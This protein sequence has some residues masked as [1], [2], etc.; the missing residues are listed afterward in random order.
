V[1]APPA[2]PIVAA[3]PAPRRAWRA[4]LAALLWALPLTAVGVLWGR[5]YFTL[6]EWTMVDRGNVLRGAVSYRGALYAIRAEHNSPPRSLAWDTYDV[7]RGATLF[8]LY[9][10]RT[11]EQVRLGFLIARW[12]PTAPAPPPGAMPP[13]A[14]SVAPWLFTP[15]FVAYGVPF[16]P[17]AA[18]LS[19]PAGRAAWRLLLR[20]R[21]ARRGLCP[22]CGYDVRASETLCPE[23]AQPVPRRRH[24]PAAT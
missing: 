2:N 9:D 18:A 16:W 20:A 3:I 22:G 23:C 12:P 13:A 1:A 19:L 24:R 11:L 5:S 10:P 15:P 17:V 7:P 21:R 8:N 4:G 6:D 14:R